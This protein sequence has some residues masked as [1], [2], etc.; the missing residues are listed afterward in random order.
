MV[1]KPTTFDTIAINVTAAGGT[2]S[3]AR[4][5]VYADNGAGFPG[6]LVVDAGT[7]AT[8]SI[9]VK[10]IALILPL[11]PGLYW[12]V[13]EDAQVTS[14][15]T[16]STCTIAMQGG[17]ITLNSSLAQSSGWFA[18]AQAGALPATWPGAA[19]SAGQVPVP[20]LVA[21]RS[22]ING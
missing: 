15:P 10:S 21:L 20:V 19:G 1:S 5:G 11:S 2:G 8:D 12:L 18:A 4:L 14:A 6:V 17:H 22:Y 16:L 9:G 3:K 13:C 7:V